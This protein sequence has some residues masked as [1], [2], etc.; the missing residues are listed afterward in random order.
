MAKK[1]GDALPMKMTPLAEVVQAKMNA[2][3][4]THSDVARLG[5]NRPTLSALLVRRTLYRTGVRESTLL[6]LHESMGIPMSVLRRA[7]QRST[8]NHVDTVR[9][10]GRSASSAT[11]RP[12]TAKQKAAERAELQRRLDELDD[13]D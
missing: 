8:I 13:E 2:E 4:W 12:H 3:R 10:A 1:D 5:M 11:D 9:S 6:A 7:A